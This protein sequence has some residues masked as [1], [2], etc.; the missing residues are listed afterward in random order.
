MIDTK[1]QEFSIRTDLAVEAKESFE[2]D[3]VEI[4]GVIIEEIFEEESQIKITK[5]V[6]ATE[7]GA[8]AMKKPKGNYITLEAVNMDEDDEDYHR[9]ISIELA[10]QIKNLI[11]EQKK[12]K[13]EE[14]SFLVVGLGNRE[15]TPDSLG[16]EVFDNL[17]ITRHVIKEYGKESFGTEKINQISGIAPGVMAQTGMEALEILKGVVKETRPDMIIV[18]DA[19][20]ARNTNRLNRTIQITDTGIHPG[21]GVGNNRKGLTKESL[22]VPVIAIGVPTVVDAATI[23]NDTME[24]F[25]SLMK[26]CI[27]ADVRGIICFGIGLTLRNGNREYFHDA[28]NAHFPGLSAKYRAEFGERYEVTSANNEEIMRFF[29]SECRAH[30]ILCTPDECFSYLRHFPEEPPAQLELF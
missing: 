2:K 20:A 29:Y 27:Q 13:E 23:V 17:F 19:L 5:V 7:E 12:E 28:L 14:Q 9:E 18:V 21:S 24:N 1:T 10:K 16:P 25:S 30:K 22:K 6:I 11:W 26:S 3:N 4:K 8:N 15:I